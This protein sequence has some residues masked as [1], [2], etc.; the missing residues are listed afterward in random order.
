VEIIFDYSSSKGVELANKMVIKR[1]GMDKSA[2][3]VW[4]IDDIY[5]LEK[6]DSGIKILDTMPMF[7]EHKMN[8][9]F[10][11]RIGMN[12]SDTMKIMSLAHIRIG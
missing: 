11:K 4:G 7:R 2:E 6:W 5:T 8:Y 10:Y 12:I 3:L 1:G 9:P